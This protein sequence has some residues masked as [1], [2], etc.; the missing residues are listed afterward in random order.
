MTS[1]MTSRSDGYESAGDLANQRKVADMLE[2]KWGCK[3][4]KTPRFYQFD[5]TVTQDTAVK[6]FCEI[7]VRQAHYDELILSLH[8]WK[9]GVEMSIHT[10]LPFLLV[11]STPKGLFWRDIKPGPLAVV[12][13]GRKDRGDDQDIEP[14]V[15]IPMSSFKQIKE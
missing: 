13:A 9:S 10:G 7:K 6:A 1:V 5:Y 15:L 14:C 11:V 3:L 2:K 8:K 12:I 4:V